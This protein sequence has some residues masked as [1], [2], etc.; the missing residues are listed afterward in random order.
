MSTPLVSIIIRS[1]NEERWIKHCLEAVYEQTY[2]NFE[3]ILVDNLSTDGTLQKAAKFPVKI[4]NLE[5]YLPGHSLNFGIEHSKGEILVFLSGHCIPVNNTWL[6]NL[7]TALADDKIAGVYGRQLPMSFTAAQDKRDLLITFGL[8]EKIQKKDSFFHNANSAIKRSVW[9]RIPFDN[10]VT[11]IEDRIWAS[12]VLKQGYFLK[13]TP[14]AAVYHHHGIHHGGNESRAASTLE[15]MEQ[16]TFV[17]NEASHGRISPEKMEIVALIPVKGEKLE[18]YQELL[19]QKTIEYA[20]S[21]SLIKKVVVL[22]ESDAIKKIAVKHGALVPF[23][24]D[25]SLSKEYIDLSMLYEK[26]LPLLEAAGIHPDLLVSLE[27]TYLVRPPQLI[28][29]MILELL[30]CGYDSIVPAFL[31]YNATWKSENNERVDDGEI[32]RSKKPPLHVT[33]KGLGMVVYPELVRHGQLY[34]QHLGRFIMKNRFS[35]VEIQ[36]ADDLANFKNLMTMAH[37]DHK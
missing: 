15:V 37:G 3:V 35:K 11:N 5:K 12:E 6:G 4:V 20:K 22:T 32:P 13:Y 14:D 31:E 17:K 21:F 36:S 1:K 18:A 25:H 10:K 28:S 8:D 33:D 34:G 24:R 23:L 7:V 9:E 27:P 16:F 30:N 29:E 26:C 2:K 19:L